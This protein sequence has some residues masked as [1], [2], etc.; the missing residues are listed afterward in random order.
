MTPTKIARPGLT[1]A[2]LDPVVAAAGPGGPIGPIAKINPMR[3]RGISAR[4]H[5]PLSWR[6]SSMSAAQ[7]RSQTTAPGTL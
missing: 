2:A 4:I 3:T 5:G 6:R 7:I 1:E